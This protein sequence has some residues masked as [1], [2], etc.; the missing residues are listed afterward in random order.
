VEEFVCVLSADVPQF[1]KAAI[2]VAM[3]MGTMIGSPVYIFLCI[4][5]KLFFNQV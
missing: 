2:A 4:R 3:T 5:N 1:G